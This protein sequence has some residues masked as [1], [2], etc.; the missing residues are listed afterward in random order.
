MRIALKTTFAILTLAILFV[1][2]IAAAPDEVV[3]ALVNDEEI[4]LQ[5]LDFELGPFLKA[6]A[7]GKQGLSL[8]EP[9]GILRRLIQNRL[10]EQEGYRIGADERFQVVNTV[11][12]YLRAKATVALLDSVTNGAALGGRAKLDSLL[13]KSSSMRRYSHI[14]VPLEE[15]ASALRDSLDLGVPFEDLA[16]RHSQDG[17]AAKGG[18]LG[19]ARRG[20]YVP[21][22]ERAAGELKIGEVI[23]PLETSFGWH[24][25]RLDDVRTESLGDSDD[26]AKAMRQKIEKEDRMSASRIYLDALRDEYQVQIHEELVRSLNFGSDDPAEIAAL[27]ASEAVIV[28]MPGARLTVKELNRN[29]LFTH[30]HGLSGKPD[31]DQIRDRFLSDW[32]DEILLW[33]EVRVN[34]LDKTPALQLG[35]KQIEREQLREEV[36][37]SVLSVRY[38]PTPDQIEDFYEGNP[39]RFKRVPRIKLRSVLLADEKG[40]LAFRKQLEQGAKLSWLSSRF[41]G[42][43]AGEEAYP[44]DWIESASMN[45]TGEEATEGRIL[46]PFR[47]MKGWAVAVVHAVEAP[48]APPLAECRG[49]VIAQMK[50]ERNR[51]TLESAMARLEENSEIKVMKGAASAVENHMLETIR[52]LSEAGAAALE[53]SSHKEGDRS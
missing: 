18:D 32:I 22:F 37:I 2:P 19:W 28:E 40:A 20:A 1:L 47:Q 49:E 17:S 48:E 8:P 4:T 45:L 15:T 50:K 31:A 27:R 51:M 30:F 5:D 34:G 12:Q 41:E 23:G 21:E 53:A 26:M 46:G 44:L 35:A 52:G 42:V 38:E 3:L 33:Q 10:L 43:V 24:I 39:D 6:F 11:N 9:D 16:R 14:I 7:D 29:I 13:D 36:L 25:V